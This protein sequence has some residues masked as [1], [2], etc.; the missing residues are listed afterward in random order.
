M[1]I[2]LLQN[3]DLPNKMSIKCEQALIDQP[4]EPTAL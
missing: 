3:V 1:Y 2:K 4:T